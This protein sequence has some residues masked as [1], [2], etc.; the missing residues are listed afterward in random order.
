MTGDRVR[1]QGKSP[2]SRILANTAWLLGGKG[3]GAACSLVYLAILTRSLGLKDFGHFA[4]IMGTAQALIALAGFE[5]WRVVVRYGA[6]HVHR[7]DW[8]RLGRL[9]MLCGVIDIIG[10]M[11]GCI[12]AFIAIYGFAD[13]LDLNPL[14]LDTAF[15]FCCAMLWALVS[16]PTGLVRA[17]HRFD[18]AVYVES[19]VP[20]GRLVAAVVIWLTGPSVGRFLLAWAL[21]D[22]LE[23]VCYWATARHLCPDAVKLR[24]LRHW[25]EALKENPR[26]PQFFLVTHAGATIDALTRYGPLLA[27]G[28]LVGTKAAGLYR[29]ASQL[30]QAMGKLSGLLTRAVYAEAAHTRVAAEASDFRKLAKQTSLMAGAGGLLVVI[31]AAAIGGKLLALIGG[32]GFENGAVILIPLAIGASFELASVAFEPVLHSSGR[33]HFSL[34]ARILVAVVLGIAILSLHNF[35]AVGI[36]WAA[37]IAGATGY[38]VLG[39]MALGSL[40]FDRRNAAKK[41][42]GDEPA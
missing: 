30:T 8:G 16:T 39:L 37:A 18:V 15:W 11:I 25:R 34:L 10:A 17:L 2:L 28:G 27:V 12:I 3:V 20:L 31:V 42:N 4:L 13:A 22:I 38:V 21:I 33:A 14:F 19:V 26:L 9:V 32:P 41:T 36:A 5:T 35:G 1:Q 40:R 6:E 29:L 7:Q 24:H 23:A